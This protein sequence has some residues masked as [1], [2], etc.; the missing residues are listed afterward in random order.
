MKYLLFFIITVIAILPL[1]STGT[2]SF[3]WP[4]DRP[5]QLTGSFA[6]FRGSRFHYGIDIG[7][8][9]NTG[10]RVF[11]AEKGSVAE[12]IHQNYGIGFCVVLRHA[13]GITSLYGHLESFAPKILDHPKMQKHKDD[14]ADHV[15]FREKFREGEITVDK[16]ELIAFTGNSGI[17]PEH[18]HFEVC[19]ADDNPFNPLIAGLSVTDIDPPAI[20]NII[21]VPLDGY[22]SIN[23]EYSRVEIP[24]IK[25]KGGSSLK[26]ESPLKI[27]GRVGVIVDAYDT[28]GG[29]NHIGIYR[30][31]VTH[32]GIEMRT[33]LFDRF[34]NGES[35]HCALFY[36]ISTST[37]SNYRYFL[38]NRS[39]GTGIINVSKGPDSQIIAATVSDAAGNAVRYEIPVIREREPSQPYWNQQTNSRAGKYFSLASPD[40]K[41]MLEVQKGSTLYDEEIRFAESIY[42]NRS[43]R[44]LVPLTSAYRFDPSDLCVTEPVT[45]T[46]PLS[47]SESPRAG[48]YSISASG[49]IRA[50]SSYYDKKKKAL[51]ARSWRLTAYFA[52]R[53]NAIPRMRAPRKILT[54]EEFAIRAGDTGCGVNP[55]SVKI[56]ID[57]RNVKFYHDADRAAFIILPH[58]DIWKAGNHQVRSSVSDN[59][60]NKSAELSFRYRITNGKKY[61]KVTAPRAY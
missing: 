56:S 32:N 53:D 16:A 19:D 46:I 41:C 15:N 13:G 12:I 33:I 51:I 47:E 44:N 21:L 34:T 23:G 10:Y 29:K 61:A 26:I 31:G 59:A 52:A 49:T 42:V 2:L 24:V 6:E 39:T 22:S 36:D 50:E 9:G 60:G 43:P 54:G 3:V 11:A 27:T 28:C 18:L 25:D 35:R 8:D 5:V 37:F 14:I 17:G 45:I 4:V 55:S 58:N 7:C 40:G 1:E 30:G 48:V 57:G 20:D 38:Y